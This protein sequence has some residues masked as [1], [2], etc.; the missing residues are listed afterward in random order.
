MK[1]KVNVKNEKEYKIFLKKLPLYRLSI[2]KLFKFTIENSYKDVNIIVKALNIKSRKKRITFVYD[3]TVK[4]ID[5]YYRCKNLCDFRKEI[6]ILH[7]KSGKMYKCGCCR[8]C[9]Y[10]NNG[11]TTKNI[12]CKMFYCS[13]IKEK[14]KLLDYNDLKILNSLGIIS[15][16]IIKSDYFAKR[17]SVIIDAYLGFLSPPVIIIRNIVNSIRFSLKKMPCK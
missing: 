16:T 4:I 14:N 7:R 13:P 9:I 17:E 11:C 2:F 10:N 8:K 1:I 5:D 6:C 15:R 3:E 12:A